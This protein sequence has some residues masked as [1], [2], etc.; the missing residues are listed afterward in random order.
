ML[1]AAL[2]L[3]GALASGWATTVSYDSVPYPYGPTWPFPAGASVSFKQWDPTLFPGQTLDSVEFDLT[4]HLGG[5]MKYTILQGTNLDITLGT[6]G[7]VDLLR[8]D[9]SV[10]VVSLPQDIRFY[11]GVSY[12]STDTVNL[13]VLNSANSGLL[14][15]AADLLLFTGAGTVTTPLTAQSNSADN[16]VGSGDNSVSFSH[17][18]EMWAQGKVTYHYHDNIPEPGTLGLF[19]LG[20]VGVGLRA[21]KGRK[22]SA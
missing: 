1:V 22:T 9:L 13:D 21:R 16:A 19:L 7:E 6:K 15:N 20:L 12:P 2:L 4:G 5:T 8:P 11:P 3:F 18:P 17:N 14:N 10:L